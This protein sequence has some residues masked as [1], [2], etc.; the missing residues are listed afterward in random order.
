MASDHRQKLKEKF[1]DIKYFSATTDIWSRSNRSFIAVSVHYFDCSLGKCTEPLLKTDF[2]ACEHFSGRHTHDRV[3]EKL[4]AIFDRFGIKEKVYFVTTDGAGEYVAAFKYF[5]DN[6]ESIHLHDENDISIT[7]ASDTTATLAEPNSVVDDATTREP[8]TVTTTA[9]LHVGADKEEM[10]MDTDFDTDSFMNVMYKGDP[11]RN[12][13]ELE[14]DSFVLH[15]LNE[16]LGLTAHNGPILGKINRIECSAHKMDKLAS[17]D[18]TKAMDD[19]SDYATI[20]TRIF[21]KLNG[22]WALKESRLSS[23]IFKQITGKSII[24]PHRFRW[25][26]WFQAVSFNLRKKI[27][28]RVL[29]FFF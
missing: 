16:I 25:L 22:I 7:S 3:A 29:Y 19:D 26:K 12:A 27:G 18:A 15:D 24:G 20:C 13:K 9:S 14:N 11:P 5:G 2:I 17:I 8:T 4:S 23:E 10:M 28:F 6:Y 21:G 1:K